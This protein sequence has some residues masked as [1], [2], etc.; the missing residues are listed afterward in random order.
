MWLIQRVNDEKSERGKDAHVAPQ[1]V[2][3]GTI[4]SDEG[5]VNRGLTVLIFGVDLLDGPEYR[6]LQFL[7]LRVRRIFPDLL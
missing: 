2:Q 3:H 5:I 1:Q 7:N 4:R 6:L